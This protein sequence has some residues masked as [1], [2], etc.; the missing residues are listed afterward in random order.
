MPKLLQAQPMRP[1]TQAERIAR[2]DFLCSD[3][4]K[5]ERQLRDLQEQIARLLDGCE[6]TDAT[7]RSAIIGGS[8]KVCA[9]C[10]RIVAPHGDR[11]WG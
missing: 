11:L 6:H 4:A 2:K 1:L 10:G 3:V 5:L 7:G 9:H 8:T